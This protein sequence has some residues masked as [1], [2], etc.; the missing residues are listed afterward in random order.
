[1]RGEQ[2]TMRASMYMRGGCMRRLCDPCC[3]RVYGPILY[4]HAT[5]SVHGIL[6]RPWPSRCNTSAR[7]SDATDGL[8]TDNDGDDDDDASAWLEGA[9]S[10]GRSFS[11][12]PG[13]E[14][15]C[16]ARQP[17][18]RVSCFSTPAAR[19]AFKKSGEIHRKPLHSTAAAPI[20]GE[21]RDWTRRRHIYFMQAAAVGLRDYRSSEY[22]P[23]IDHAAS[24]MFRVA[25][26]AVGAESSLPAS[27][28]VQSHLKS[29]SPT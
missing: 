3:F 4:M 27:A 10:P 29:E 18:P 19:D 28:F 11:P 6:A 13:Q 14:N 12:Q 20:E 17:P 8:L 24:T 7:A 9:P 23:R 2:A 16:G 26:A 1:M 15:I 22:I 21:A 5:R 25:Q